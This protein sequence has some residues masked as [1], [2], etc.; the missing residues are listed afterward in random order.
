MLLDDLAGALFGLISHTHPELPAIPVQYPDYAVWQ[1][2]RLKSE[3]AAK[4]ADFWKQ[5]LQS[6]QP[7][8]L[9]LDYTRP[10]ELSFRGASITRTLD[11]GLSSDLSELGHQAHIPL[12]AILLS[13]LQVLLSRFSGQT[14]FAIGTA[15]SGR[16][17]HDIE[18][19]VGVFVNTLAYPCRFSQGSTL[20]EVISATTRFSNDALAHQDLPFEQLIE[21]LDLE[22]DLGRAPIFQVLYVHQNT[23]LQQAK[24]PGL[25]F[26]PLVQESQTSKFELTV[27]SEQTEHGLR[28]SF[29]YNTALFRRETIQRWI[30]SFEVLLHAFVKQRGLKVAQAPI[31]PRGERDL[32]LKFAN[33]GTPL[34]HAE[35]RLCHVAIA[36][37]CRL[38]PDALATSFSDGSAAWTY[39]ELD[40]RAEAIAHDLAHQGCGP[41]SIVGYML[42][43][44]PEALAA[45]LGILKS[46]AAYLPIDPNYP[47]E[48][49]RYMIEDSGAAA[50]IGLGHDLAIDFRSSDREL[51]FD[52]PIYLIYTSGSTGKPKGALVHHGGPKNLALWYQREVKITHDS[53][54]LIISSL[55]FDLTQKNLLTPLM[56]GASVYFLKSE[57]FDPWQILDAIEIRGITHIN[58]AP[59]ALYPIV[60][61]AAKSE[62]SALKSLRYVVLG[63]ETIAVD[64]L[65]AWMRHPAINVRVLNSYGPTETSDVCSADWV[66]PDDT[67][68]HI[69][70]PLPGSTVYVIDDQGQ[71]TPTG[72]EGEIAIGG[73]GVGH[74]YWN[75]PELTADRFLPDPY[76]G[77]E[78]RLYRTGD[79]GKVLP[80][81]KISFVG[82]KDFQVKI[83]GLRVELGEIEHAVRNQPGVRSCAVIVKDAPH[84]PRLVA[85]YES[86]TDDVQIDLNALGLPEYMIPGQMVWIEAMPH[87]PSGKTDYKTLGT[88]QLSPQKQ[89]EETEALESAEEKALGAIWCKI[90]NLPSIGRNDDFFR[91]GGDSILSIQVIANAREVGYALTP[92]DLFRHPTL[93]ALAK[94]SQHLKQTADHQETLTGSCPLGPIQRWFF[95]QN[96]PHAEHWNQSMLLASDYP[97]NAD[98]LAA[99]LLKLIEHHDAL[100]LVFGDQAHFAKPSDLEDRLLIVRPMSAFSEEVCKKLQ[101]DL[102]LETGPL[103]R[104][105]LFQDNEGQSARLLLIAHH[106]VVDGVSWQIILEDLATLYAAQDSSEAVALPTKSINLR[107]WIDQLHAY[108]QTEAHR[109]AQVYWASQPLNQ[110]QALPR[111]LPQGSNLAADSRYVSTHLS[112]R[113]TQAL[114][115]H[116]EHIQTLLLT[117]LARTLKPWTQK[118]ANW[119]QVEGHGRILPGSQVNNSRTVGWFTALYPVCLDTGF[120]ADIAAQI[121][122]IGQ[123]LESIPNGGIDA[124]ILNYISGEASI[125]QPEIAFNFLG[126]VDRNTSNNLLGLRPAKEPSGSH[127]HPSNPRPYLLEINGSI[128]EGELE[129]IWSYS[130]GVHHPNTIDALAQQFAS[131]LLTVTQIDTQQG[132]SAVSATKIK[133]KDMKKLISKFKSST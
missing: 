112:N 29:E 107:D 115:D 25:G 76:T 19:T 44:G 80:S 109:A 42:P 86:E 33:V 64:R 63:G 132:S 35:P 30:D 62:F 38:T 9:P 70:T 2:A 125:P 7:L 11:S 26:K 91:I 36:Q 118:Q 129:L 67:E 65:S 28:L 104:A 124:G 13:G 130:A 50:V 48:R 97:L 53:R 73:V 119:V 108:S 43:P 79:L 92:R 56:S 102:T 17:H 6:V 55:S 12:F 93:S 81:G 10:A 47:E 61:L 14:D 27:S 123:R 21:L 32:L 101:G 41:G 103:F 90:L 49:I 72:C 84:N 120:S 23:P 100:R 51:G 111:D 40:E 52:D 8:E 114:L 69:G 88:F 45:I 57:A 3:L 18:Q 117:A 16:T 66:L 82:R 106:L 37:Q 126:Q 5:T 121:K 116:S 74:G 34:T 87:T 105:A 77:G 128:R 58:C 131:E 83:R 4:Q 110:I 54:F 68:T 94:V 39:A 59:S 71:L 31:M 20:D 46:G 85:F 15:V 122:K 60:E 75:R 96:F 133:S 113:E 78:R 22:R 89:V 95:D 127:Y 98:H 24:I 99:A 1:R